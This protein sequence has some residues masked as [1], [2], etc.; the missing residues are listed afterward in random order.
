M[1][2]DKV[3]QNLK[4]GK[5]N[6]NINYDMNW[7]QLNRKEQTPNNMCGKFPGHKSSSFKHMSQE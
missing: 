3:K 7:Q 4:Q 1:Q 2:K 6:T 5:E